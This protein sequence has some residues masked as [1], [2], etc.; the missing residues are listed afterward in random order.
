MDTIGAALYNEALKV[1]K[2]RKVSEINEA[3]GVAAA[4]KLVLGKS[5]RESV[6]TVSALDTKKFD[7]DS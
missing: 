7:S 6:W 5:M 1:L 2:P 3:G 4:V